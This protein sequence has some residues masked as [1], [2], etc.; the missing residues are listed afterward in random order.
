MRRKSLLQIKGLS[1]V[2]ASSAGLLSRHPKQVHALDGIDLDIYEQETLGIVG[3]SGCGKTTLGRTII[4]LIAP[5][6]GQ[7]LYDG[8]DLV[9]ASKEA[10]KSFN[11]EMQMVFQNP[12]TSFDPRFT[13]IKCVSEPLKIHT[14]LR[15]EALTIRARELLEQ[16]GMPGEILHRYAHEFSGGQLQRIAIARALA[17]N[18]KLIVLD[19]PTS[20]LDVSVQAQIINLLQDLQRQFKLTYLFISHDLSVVQHI[21]NRVT[22]MYLGKIVEQNTSE[23]IF[24]GQAHHPYTQALLSAMPSV[25]KELRREQIILEGSVPDAANPPNGCNFHPRCPVAMPI[26]SKVEPVLDNSGAGHPVA[27]F[28]V[29]PIEKSTDEI[30]Q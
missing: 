6:S 12:Y 25:V 30:I 16:V 13:I 10:K 11:R 19:E 24:E 27:C 14:K 8:Q 2:F 1:K 15:G 23:S 5:T 26:C 7:I 17:L 21:S 22:V 20:A 4:G 3:E 18:P 29:N 9:N 28:V